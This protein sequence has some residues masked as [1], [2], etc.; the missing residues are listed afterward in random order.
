MYVRDV[1]AAPSSFVKQTRS[2]KTR[3]GNSR[4][5]DP[6]LR[7]NVGPGNDHH[8]R[9]PYAEL[10]SGVPSWHWH[11]KALSAGLMRREVRLAAW[12]THLVSAAYTTAMVTAA[13]DAKAEYVKPAL[14][15]RRSNS[16]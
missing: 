14:R 4:I 7:P 9:S 15:R 11:K 6:G 3:L 12:P 10:P 13:K 8:V 5:P 2:P 16:F 1:H